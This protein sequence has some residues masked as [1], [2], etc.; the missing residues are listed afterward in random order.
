MVK[1]PLSLGCHTQGASEV[2]LNFASSWAQEEI[3]MSHRH[4][5][6]GPRDSKKNVCA[7]NG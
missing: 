2:I 3:S 5:A 6:S 4:L 7:Q 1:I